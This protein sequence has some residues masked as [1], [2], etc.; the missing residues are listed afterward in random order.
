MSN[1]LSTEYNIV[2][3]YQRQRIL[4]KKEPKIDFKQA[5]KL[6]LTTKAISI[7]KNVQPKIKIVLTLTRIQNG[8]NNNGNNQ[9][10]MK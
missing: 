8:N 5:T 6:I 2:L 7:K 10:H 4:Q 3:I 9:V 1:W